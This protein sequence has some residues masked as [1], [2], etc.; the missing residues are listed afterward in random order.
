MS[1]HLVLTGELRR[2]PLHEGKKEKLQLQVHCGGGRNTMH[3]VKINELHLVPAISNAAFTSGF[4]V[5]TLF[6]ATGMN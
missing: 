1:R 4:C 6:L 2:A 5:D 3:L